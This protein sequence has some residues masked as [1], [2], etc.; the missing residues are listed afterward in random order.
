MSLIDDLSLTL[1]QLGCSDSEQKPCH[2]E[3]RSQYDTRPGLKSFSD[4]S[5]V[6][7]NI[8]DSNTICDN[9]MLKL[10]S[11]TFTMCAKLIMFS[12]L[13]Y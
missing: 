4:G 2:I 5:S 13:N 6:P 9:S 10:T 8:N 3:G 7:Q 1:F 12:S 11:T